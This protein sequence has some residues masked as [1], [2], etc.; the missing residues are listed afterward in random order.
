[1]CCNQN[2]NPKREVERVTILRAFADAIKQY[3]DKRK[4][5]NDAKVS[6]K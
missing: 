6:T 5:S 1:M 2:Q 4:G 3:R